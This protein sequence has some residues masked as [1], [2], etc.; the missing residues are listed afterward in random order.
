M[1]RLVSLIVYV[2]TDYYYVDMVNH[3]GKE[4]KE[5][6]REKKGDTSLM[7]C[8]NRTCDVVVFLGNIHINVFFL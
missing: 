3:E 2:D 7:I 5:K 6:Q 1:I 8:H 4:R